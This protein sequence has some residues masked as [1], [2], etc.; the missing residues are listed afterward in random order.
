MRNKEKHNDIKDLKAGDEVEFRLDPEGSLIT[1]VIEFIA[2]D[3]VD[4]RLAQGS[5][6]IADPSSLSGLK[7]VQ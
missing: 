6:I 7:K 4:V 3:S 5:S 1:G 2:V